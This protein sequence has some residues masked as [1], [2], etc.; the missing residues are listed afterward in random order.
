MSPSTVSNAV[1]AASVDHE[2]LFQK[3]FKSV[4][5]RTYAAQV[6]KAKNGNHYVTLIEGRRDEK[7][8][9]VR[10]TKLLVFSEDFSEFFK[11]VHDLAVFIRENPVPEN[12]RQRRTKFWEKQKDGAPVRQDRRVASAKPN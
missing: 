7:T 8:D 11:L 6:K 12:V 1:P 2:I 10:K 3:Y 4:G 5:P 9:E